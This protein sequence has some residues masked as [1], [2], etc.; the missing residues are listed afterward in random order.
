[1]PSTPRCEHS[2]LTKSAL[3]IATIVVSAELAHRIDELTGKDYTHRKEWI[4]NASNPSLLSS[5][6]TFSE[7]AVLPTIYMS[8][9]A[10]APDVVA[11]WSDEEVATRWL[12][13]FPVLTALDVL[14]KLR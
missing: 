2:S 11:T 13:L 14:P 7:Y 5:E 9:C 4:R 12:R 8:F 1:M 3:S 6:S 10:I